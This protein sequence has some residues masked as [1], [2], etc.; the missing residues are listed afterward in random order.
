MSETVSVTPE[1]A[2]RCAPIEVIA[3]GTF[4]AF[5][6]RFCA[7]TMISPIPVLDDGAGA[8]GAGAVCAE[9]ALAVV[10]ADKPTVESNTLRTHTWLPAACRMRTVV[11]PH[12]APAELTQIRLAVVISE[13][14][15]REVQQ[16]GDI[17]FRTSVFPLL[18]QSDQFQALPPLL[19]A[20]IGRTRIVHHAAPIRCRIAV[21]RHR[22][23][24]IP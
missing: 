1:T 10:T 4:W 15:L 23:L 2:S 17:T 6:E 7:V 24:H 14:S 8:P 13:T 21:L 16:R 9:T 11:P 3:T 18:K 5:S 22:E 19:A 12:V 20:L